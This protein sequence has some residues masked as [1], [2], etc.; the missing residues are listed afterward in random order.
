V[1]R[2]NRF[3]AKEAGK[4]PLMVA[5]TPGLIS[6]VGEPKKI[7]DLMT[8]PISGRIDRNS[9]RVWPWR[10]NGFTHTPQNPRFQSD[11][12]E[13]ELQVV[14]NGWAFGQIAAFLVIPYIRQGLL[15]PVL[16]Q[17]EPP[18]LPLYVYRPQRGPVPARVRKVF[19]ILTEGF[20]DEESFPSVI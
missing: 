15:V 20:A 6:E 16:R 8:R 5:G 13:A 4:V 17:F 12:P 3:V 19:D 10:F 18:P 14:L 9:G 7:S 2:D 1:L 11:D